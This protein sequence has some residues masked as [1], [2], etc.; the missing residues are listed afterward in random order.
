[1]IAAALV[2]YVVSRVS[3]YNMGIAANGPARLVACHSGTPL[4]ANSGFGFPPEELPSETTAKL[5]AWVACKSINAHREMLISAIDFD[6]RNTALFRLVTMRSGCSDDRFSQSQVAKCESAVFASIDWLLDKGV[7]LNPANSCGYL[8]ETYSTVL[9][10]DMFEFLLARGASINSTCPSFLFQEEY[11]DGE[12]VPLDWT[13]VDD[14]NLHR[15][16]FESDDAPPEFIE[17]VDSRFSR[18]LKLAAEIANDD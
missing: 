6:G 18:I 2:P 10:E 5:D 4:F 7:D 8:R 9:D 3:W 15:Q 17:D 11:P 12:E 14:V 13:I 16:M 1:L